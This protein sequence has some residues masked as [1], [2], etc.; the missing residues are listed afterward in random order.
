MVFYGV[1]AVLIHRQMIL[2]RNHNSLT[3]NET[4]SHLVGP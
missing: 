2:I 4:D 1:C 3:G